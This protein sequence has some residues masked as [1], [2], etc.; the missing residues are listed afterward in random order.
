MRKMNLFYRPAFLTSLLA[1]GAIM[2]TAACAHKSTLPVAT[3]S[4]PITNETRLPASLPEGLNQADV[5]NMKAIISSMDATHFQ[6][7]LL[8]MREAQTLVSAFDMR[9]ASIKT[10]KQVDQLFQSQLYCDLMNVRAI[11]EHTEEQLTY[12]LTLAKTLGSR[13]EDWYFQQMSSFANTDLAREAAIVQLFRGLVNN[14]ITICGKEGCVSNDIAKLTGFHVKPLDN[15]DVRRFFKLNNKNIAISTKINASDLTTGDCFS[16]AARKPQDVGYDWANRNW[17]GSVL[18]AGQFV[19]TYDD[20]P[21]ATFTRDIRDTW[22]NAGMPKPA[23]FWLRKNASTYASIVKELNDQ[24]YVIG[25]HSERHADLGNLAK[26][27]G[28]ATFNGVNK[29]IFGDETKGLTGA[30]FTQWKDNTLN[31]EINQSVA[32][33]SVILGKPVRYFRLPYGSGVRNDLIGARFQALNLEHF[34]WRVDS[35]DWQ[36]KNPESVRDRVVAQMNVVKRGIVLFHDIHPQ[37]A[38]AAKL[39]VQFLKGNTTYKAV[40]I[41]DIPGLKP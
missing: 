29:Q 10:E 23:F 34:F 38:Q 39:M 27:T 15:K 40:S 8:K 37:S 17:V 11:H 25:S 4:A 32:D 1:M 22:A 36:D 18:P 9:I 35:L 16:S 24:S 2:L 6:Q 12:G 26:A 30:A 14:E 28:P 3:T 7:K 21:H 5:D 19:F 41:S 33:L 20:G 13:F 31:R